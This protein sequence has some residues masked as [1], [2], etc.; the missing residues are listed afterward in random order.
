MKSSFKLFR[1]AGID[2][3]IH[4]SWFFIFVF[5]AWTLA[6]G[7]YP[8]QFAGWSTATYWIAGIVSSLM[9]FI[10][11]LIHELTHSFVARARGIPVH[12]ITLFI[13]GG[14]SNLE[15]EPQKPLAEFVMAIVGPGSSLVLAAIFLVIAR[16]AGSVNAGNPVLDVIYYLG[17]I[18]LYL[19]IFNLLPGFPLDGGRVLRS[20]I[21]GATND[22]KKATNVAATV[23]R[24]IGWL[25]IAA[26][27]FFLFRYGSLFNG[28]WLAFIGWFLMSAADAS[29]K[30]I[31]IRERLSHVKIRDVMS[32][33]IPTIT[34]E[35]TVQDLVTGIFRK[36]HDRAVPVC[37]NNQLMGIATITDI[38]KVPQEKWSATPVK[39][40]MTSQNLKT[41]LPD[42]NL[43]TAFKLITAHDINQVIVKENDKCAGLLSRADILRYLQV[44]QE[45]GMKPPEGNAQA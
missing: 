25:F 34:P 38:K 13:L 31:A 2:V 5:F 18:N 11:V 8:S 41:V 29:R 27:V 7:Y 24:V 23:G 20:I 44:S 21:W 45:M 16:F 43:N 36:E 4:Y 30:E 37:M 33:K 28:L 42:D 6:E 12:S 22:L 35:T 39:D 3:G 1:V 19:G 15:E 26:G 10:S 40:I 17:I 14:V 9:I 32:L